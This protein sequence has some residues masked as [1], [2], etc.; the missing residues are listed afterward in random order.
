MN[1]KHIREIGT[2]EVLQKRLAKY[3]ALHCF[4]NTDVLEDLHS[5]EV[6][7]S[8]AGDYSDVRV[9]TPNGQI[10]W[11]DLSRLD[12][13][14]MKA[15]MIDVVNH[16]DQV[17]AILFSTPVGDKLIEELGRRDLVPYWSDPEWT[18]GR[19]HKPQVA[20]DLPMKRLAGERKLR[21]RETH[22]VRRGPA[23]KK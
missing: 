15:L 5:G 11:S 18:Q 20:R 6:P 12:N 3:I 13:R 2:N 17:L 21:R 9:I 14:E 7:I 23:G 8:E 22:K 4:R 1:P 10:P 19:D 16:C